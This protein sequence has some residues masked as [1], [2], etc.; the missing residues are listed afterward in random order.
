MA[1]KR[2][3]FYKKGLAILC[4]G[5]S[6]FAFG[7]QKDEK[8]IKL[9]FN[10]LVLAYG[11]SKPAPHLDIVY[12]KTKKIK[13]AE[14]ITQ[15]LKPTIRID[16][17]LYTLCRTYGKDSLNA[18]AIVL[19]HE[20]AHYYGDHL[21]CSDYAYAIRNTNKTLA[22]E[23]R[24]SSLSSRIE[25]ETE[26]DRNGFFYA[27]AAGFSPFGLQSDLIDKIYTEYGLPDVQLGYPT[28]QERKNIARTSE[29]E[30]NRL[31][32]YFKTGLKA[33]ED[34]KYD[35]AITAFEQANSKIPYRENYNNLG[36]A[37]TLKALEMKVLSKGEF[38]TPKR[39]QYPLEVDNTSRLKKEGTRS[40][41]DRQTM[42][43]LLVAAQKDFEEA[44]RLDPTYTK[45]HINL[46]CVYDLQGKHLSARA[47]ITEKLSKEQQ[48]SIG[49]K[50]ILAI[51]YY[52]A[53]ME[54]RAGEIWDE[55]KM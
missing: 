27:A 15:S 34:K 33:L 52:N 29:E 11:S 18:I 39:F 10:Q 32:G 30:A 53:D 20:L 6:F 4:C 43:I 14:Y 48:N 16:A 3:L 55:L 12:D 41:G 51:A 23:L 35:D 38:D 13:P 2:N 21:F 25:K 50:Q 24:N 17:Y 54:K 1:I 37:K 36:V 22:P 46:A 28:K 26:A 49:A 42:E 8:P 9:V 31:Y 47:E 19:S 44:I 7:Q 5:L 40:S 45:S